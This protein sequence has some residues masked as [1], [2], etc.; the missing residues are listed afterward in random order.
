MKF[1]L[2]EDK[3]KLI[4]KESTREEYN[5]LK[6][7][8][9]KYVKNYFFMVKYKKTKWDGKIEFLK[10]GREINF[11]LWY[12]VYKMCKEYGYPFILENK[13]FFP[14]DNSISKEHLTNW[15]NDFYKDHKDKNDITKPFTPYEH[16]IEGI[17]KILK[18]KFGIIEVATA[19]GKSLIF[20][21]LVFY[22]L[23][24][25]NKDAKFL[26]IV[27]SLDLVTQFYN[28]I[29][30]YNLGF[31]QENKN[32]LE[33]GI[34]EIMSDKPRKHFGGDPNIYIGT[35]QSLIKWN[36]DFFKQFD[37][38]CCDESHLAK[39]PTLISIME[40]TF[41]TSKIRFGMS[42]TYPMEGTA[43]L[44]T[45]ESLMGPKL[46]NIKALKLMD[47]GIISRLKINALLLNHNEKQ[48]AE[49]VYLIKK[50]GN[51]K[52]AYE[53]EKEYAQNSLPRKIFLAKLVEKFKHN[54]LLLFHNLDY[55]K[56]LY[57]YFRDNVQDKDFFYIDGE[58]PK[59]KRNAIKKEMEKTDGN[60]KILVASFGTTS[61][62]ISIRAIVNLV[63]CDSFKSDRVVRQSIGRVLRLHADKEKAIIF[64]LVDIFDYSRRGVL[65]N[66]YLSRKH[67]IY[68]RQQY[69]YTELKV[70]L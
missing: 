65:H 60:V 35:Y 2:S 6:L 64:D 53:L 57:N 58:T 62:G 5:Q 21:S 49:N 23:R 24:N 32:P 19:G 50:A 1:I 36:D 34:D 20:G 42:G 44:F 12:E 52:K 33:L 22:Y 55:G 17:Y 59:V 28:D 41:T 69:P 3:T 43:E 4:L 56:D 9:S 16:Q 48:F 54:S 51:G 47:D 30:D 29:M 68:D 70:N 18:N 40:R 8:L 14:K 67:E 45:I 31:H 66:H 25:I 61:T 37:V 63:F 15:L 13:E 7:S 11:G 27:P 26:L 39:A 10:N 46:L 38:V